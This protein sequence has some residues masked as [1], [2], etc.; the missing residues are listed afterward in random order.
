MVTLPRTYLDSW[1]TWDYSGM[2]LVRVTDYYYYF[3]EPGNQTWDILYSKARAWEY[4]VF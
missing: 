2:P 4:S 1:D 3:M